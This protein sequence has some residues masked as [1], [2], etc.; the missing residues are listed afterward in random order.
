[1]LHELLKEPF[2]GFPG[3]ALRFLK[4]LSNPK[5]NNKEWFDKNRQTYED[6]LKNPMRDLIDSLAT[7]INKIDPDI[8]VNYKSIFRIN[9]DV[10]F[11]KD[12]K[13]YKTHYA[14]A[15]AFDRV[16]S[17]EIPQFYF[18]F[19]PKEFIFAAGQYST[20]I[21]QLKKIRTAI[22]R[23]F[24]NY[25]AIILQKN[26]LKEYGNVKGVS[27]TRLPKG[28][29]NIDTFDSDPLLKSS[30]MMK[31]YYVFKSL[32]PAVILDN[33]IVDIIADNINRTYDFTKFLHNATK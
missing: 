32:K 12:K 3:K 7:E 5:N 17:A 20:D 28:Y 19:D 29:E 15:F 1:M 18:H 13:P 22:S 33:G 4:E 9:R 26:F 2:P 30:L 6:A 27:L 31:Q 24:K 25:K 8:V 21:N 14:A 23:N 11:S 10:R 16:K